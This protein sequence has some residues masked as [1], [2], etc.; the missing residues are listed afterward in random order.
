MIAYI[1]NLSP[2]KTSQSTKN[3]YFDMNL[4]TSDRHVRAVCFSAEKHQDF[5]TRFESS[6]PVKIESYSLK[7]N[8]RTSEEEVHLSKRTK[9][10][11]PEDQFDCK[12]Q[13]VTDNSLYPVTRVDSIKHNTSKLSVLG[14]VTFQGDQETIITKNKGKTLRKQDALFTD[15]TG[16]IRIVLWEDDIH[17]IN[18]GQSYKLTNVGVKKFQDTNYLTLNKQSQIASTNQ[19]IIRDD[20]PVQN[21][22]KEVLCPPKG[23]KAINVYKSC[24]NCKSKVVPN[25]ENKI[26]R[27][28]ECGFIQLT[29]TCESKL[30]ANASFDIGNG[31]DISLALFED[32]LQ[33]LHNIYI[34]QEI[35]HP[36]EF[37]KCDEVAI[38][39]MMLSV[40]AKLIYSRS[41][42]VVSVTNC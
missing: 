25:N 31:E 13:D 38:M 37:S 41:S 40:R 3:T 10:F 18:S 34:D 16:S 36:R 14:R 39:S 5:K 11:D 6:S 29:T 32:K 9:L 1:H 12:K 35:D 17:K 2:L 19:P 22:L 26:T 28:T 23:I 7:R 21:N 42:N 20:A 30:Y 4:Q 8:S 24:A 27:C 15:N 33:L